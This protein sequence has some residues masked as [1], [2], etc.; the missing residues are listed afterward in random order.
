MRKPF[1]FGTRRNMIG[2]TI[3]RNVVFLSTNARMRANLE[4]ITID[5]P[6]LAQ[7]PANTDTGRF[8]R[9]WNRAKKSALTHSTNLL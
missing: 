2:G 8:F 9:F 5:G 4:V 7:I 6:E 1:L 3:P